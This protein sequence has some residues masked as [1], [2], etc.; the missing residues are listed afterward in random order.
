M[1]KSI[2]WDEYTVNSKGCELC[3]CPELWQKQFGF[4]FPYLSRRVE[5][6]CCPYCARNLRQALED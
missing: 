2:V 3:T 4:P 6:T 5:A 1:M